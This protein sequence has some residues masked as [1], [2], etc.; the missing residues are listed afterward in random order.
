[1]ENVTLY[2]SYRLLQS[3][4]VTLYR[5]CVF[6]TIQRVSGLGDSQNPL[7]MAD[8][9]GNSM[10]KKGTLIQSLFHPIRLYSVMVHEQ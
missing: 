9:A 6:P 8:M 1:M 3:E 2:G 10:Y 4:G 7:C 5:S